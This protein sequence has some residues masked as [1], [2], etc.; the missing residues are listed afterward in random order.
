[1]QAIQDLISRNQQMTR[2]EKSSTQNTDTSHQNPHNAILVWDIFSQLYGAGFTSSFG[3][4]PSRIWIEEL[5]KF[6]PRDIEFGIE[7]CKRSGSDFAPSLPR[8]LAMCQ[9]PIVEDVYAGE[10]NAKKLIAAK[11]NY[12]CSE[13][14][15]N[16]ALAEMNKILRFNPQ[17]QEPI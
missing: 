1:M 6:S 11:P 15:K 5:A 2:L 16:S 8:F 7:Q 3:F 9:P 12:Q 13:A 14:V 10:R 4:E 17:P